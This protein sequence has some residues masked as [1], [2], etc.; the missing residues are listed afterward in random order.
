MLLIT[1]TMTKSA[2][3]EAKQREDMKKSLP[4]A[5]GRAGLNWVIKLI[6]LP[7]LLGAHV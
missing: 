4:G 1:C 6:N 5:F 3:V 2:S 7:E